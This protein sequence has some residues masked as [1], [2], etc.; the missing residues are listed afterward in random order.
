[1]QRYNI[2][3]RSVGLLALTV[4]IGGFLFATTAIQAGPADLGPQVAIA[5]GMDPDVC[6]DSEGNLHFA[7]V[8]DGGVYYR[9]LFTPYYLGKTGPEIGI[10]AGLNPQIEVDSENNPHVA[11]GQGHYSRM[12]NGRFTAPIQAVDGWRKN[13]IAIDSQDRVYIVAD[14]YSPRQVVVKVYKDGQELMTYPTRVGFDNPGGMGFDA[15]DKLHIVCRW[16]GVHYYSRY[17]FNTVEAVDQGIQSG[18]SDFAWMTVSPK[19]QSVHY[20]GTVGYAKGI[21]HK[22]MRNGQFGGTATYAVFEADTGEG[23]FVNPCIA[24][25]IDGFKYVT[26]SGRNHEGYFFVLNEGDAKIAG[27]AL[28][29]PEIHQSGGAKMTN[30]NIASRPDMGGAFIAWGTEVVTV[31]SIGDIKLGGGTKAAYNVR[32]KDFDGDGRDDPA[33]YRPATGEWFIWQSSNRQIAAHKYGTPDD[34]PV[35]G[36]FGTKAQADLAVY[37]PEQS[38]WHIVG[39]ETEEWGLKGDLPVVADY[40]NDG[41]SDYGV[42]RPATEAG[43]QNSWYIKASGGKHISRENFGVLNDYPIVGD[44]DGDGQTDLG[45]IRPH[46]ETDPG[47]TWIVERSSAGPIS[48]QFGIDGDI[49]VPDDYDGDTVDDVAIFRPSTGVWYIYMSKDGYKE[50]GWGIEGDIPVPG[51]YDGDGR[52][53][54]GIYRN[55][56]WFVWQSSGGSRSSGTGLLSSP[57]F[58]WG[59]PNTTPVQADYDDDGK[60]DVASYDRTSGIWHIAGSGAGYMGHQ[61]GIP[62][63]VPTVADF[64]GDGKD[65]VAIF[66]PSDGM[67]YARGSESAIL[68]QRQWGA[69]TDTPIPGNYLDEKFDGPAVYRE[70]TGEWFFASP[71]AGGEKVQW[72]G[73]G[74]KPVAGDIDRDGV[75]DV[76]VFEPSSGMWHSWLSRGIDKEHQFSFQ[77]G[78]PGDIPM[79]RNTSTAGAA[80]TSSTTAPPQNLAELTVYRPSDGMWYTLEV[81]PDGSGGFTHNLEEI[82]FGAPGDKPLVG[83]FDGD[84]IDDHAV[85]RN[86]EWWV[87]DSS[88]GEIWAGM[89]PLNFGTPDDQPIGGRL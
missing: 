60:T 44:F 75:D 3:R 9:K 87:L 82:Q 35:P 27:P 77:F 68:L 55:G 45:I 63:D 62:G 70:A 79:I 19:D 71:I 52:A 20:V 1:M 57:P 34:I 51:D 25:D 17:V 76:C 21:F 67:W 50:M 7:Y 6:V 30:P 14:I 23:D 47:L 10:A 11:F 5:S 22:V 49:P 8:R 72:G 4:A 86:G 41:I 74:Y 33:L 29:D 78:A 26:F 28:I 53:D 64:D 40:D 81:I 59:T 43:Q 24:A 54:V 46:S 15:N 38:Q 18:T 36:Y 73:P 42:Y 37:R 66:R 65:D 39:K 32:A 13:L 89:D 83:D 31:R 2:F 84:G 88:T 48:F 61:W 85:Y 69:P 16:K 56:I 80:G 12:V 58:N